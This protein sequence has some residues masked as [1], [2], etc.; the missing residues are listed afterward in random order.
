MHAQ[1]H[2][3]HS[4]LNKTLSASL[5]TNLDGFAISMLLLCKPE[6]L[7]QRSLQDKLIESCLVEVQKGVLGRVTL[8]LPKVTLLPGQMR[9]IPVQL[10]VVPVQQGFAKSSSTPSKFAAPDV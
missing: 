10:Y 4:V 3:D 7:G 8:S 9:V 5:R 2:L 6:R 1:V